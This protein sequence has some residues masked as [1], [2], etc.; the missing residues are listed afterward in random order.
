MR[1]F[2]RRRDPSVGHGRVARHRPMRGEVGEQVRQ[3]HQGPGNQDPERG[4]AAVNAAA[5][6]APSLLRR[7]RGKDA[8]DEGDVNDEEGK[9]V[10]PR[11]S[12]ADLVEAGPG[13]RLVLHPPCELCGGFGV[14][15][16]CETA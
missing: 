5:A 13:H 10:Q 2:P 15:W 14:R 7:G 12:R 1:G 9:E 3:Q 6:A 11:S 8:C 4:Y 16:L